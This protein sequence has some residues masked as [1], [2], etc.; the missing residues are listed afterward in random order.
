MRSVISMIWK[1]NYCIVN[2]YSYKFFAIKDGNK[3]F[4]SIVHK[5][6]NIYI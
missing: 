3:N 2:Q 6:L 1:K 5:K 4:K